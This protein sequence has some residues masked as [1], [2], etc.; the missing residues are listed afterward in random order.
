MIQRSVFDDYGSFKHDNYKAYYE[1]TDLQMHIQHDLGNEVWFQPDAVA[2]DVEHAS[3]GISST[4]LMQ[5]S[6]KVFFSKWHKA[7]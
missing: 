6:S 3:F 2:L 7:L 5:E 1:D 4:G